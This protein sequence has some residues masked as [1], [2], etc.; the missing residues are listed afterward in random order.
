MADYTTNRA[1]QP[2]F[3]K[4]PNAVLD[5]SLDV[6]AWLADVGDT[7][8]QV[9]ASTVGC[10]LAQ[11]ASFQGGVMTAFVKGGAVDVDAS[12]TFHFKTTSQPAREDDRTIILK[13]K[14]R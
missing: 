1:G 4:D 2:V 12:V 9:T 6:S 13:I 8:A 3:T 14:E 11:P 10:D 7:L 5:Y